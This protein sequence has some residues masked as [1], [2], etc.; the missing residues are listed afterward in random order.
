MNLREVLA[1]ALASLAA[2]RTQL[3]TPTGSFDVIALGKGAARMVD[4]LVGAS[5]SLRAG[6]VVLPDGAP[7]PREDPR[8][9]VLRASH[10]LPDERSVAAG[11]AALALAQGGSGAELY[12]LVSGG[13][14]SLALVP[15][16]GVTL[17]VARDVIRALL[18]SG[19][20]VRSTNVVRRH[21]SVVHGGGLQRAASSRP[22]LTFIE[23]DVIGGEAYDVGS[24]PSVPDPTTVDEAR[25]VL[26]RYAP[27][28]A[29]L[30]L[31]ET[32]KPGTAHVRVIT[33]LE[34]A[35]LAAALARE[36]RAAGTAVTVLPPSL[37]DAEA[38]A[39]DYVRLART[40]KPGDAVVRVAEPSLRITSARPGQGGR[41]THLAALV[42][43]ELPSDVS[44]L[45]AASDGVDG[46]SGTAGALVRSGSF[47]DRAG[48]EA[49]IAAFDTGTLHRA[50]G[51]AL[52]TGPT[53]LN[54]TDV[55]ALVRDP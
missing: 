25:G 30:P 8:L 43:R 41:C 2:A 22:T 9:T 39:R 19:A 28:F 5:S 3:V 53:G 38:L 55:H 7:G 54:L 13:A 12:V 14:S 45:A 44:F 51:T 49:A 48:L 26:Q 20:E 29:S 42:A 37:D 27:S 21:L 24:G 16:P 6:L 40:M 18:L 4:L 33:V 50:H 31:A 17:E 34:P 46:T 47:P 11:E 32:L 52:P 35:Q 36:L 15:V 1:R 23:S 10:P